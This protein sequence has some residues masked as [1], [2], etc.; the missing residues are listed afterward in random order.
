MWA[1]KD[2]ERSPIPILSVSQM[3]SLGENSLRDKLKD[4]C[5]FL[6]VCFIKLTKI[7]KKYI[8]MYNWILLWAILETAVKRVLML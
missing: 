1:V 3:C 4:L 5:I 8:A 7:Q 6:N 2:V